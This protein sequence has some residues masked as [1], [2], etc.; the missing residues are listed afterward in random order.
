MLS[1]ADKE[2]VSQSEA[3]EAMSDMFAT[4]A[5]AVAPTEEEPTWPYVTLPFDQ[6]ED[7]AQHVTSF[8]YDGVVWVAPIVVDDVAT[9]NTYCMEVMEEDNVTMSPQYQ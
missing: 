4:Y 8:S 7:H 1:Y 9:W 2:L 5:L 3:L 6:F